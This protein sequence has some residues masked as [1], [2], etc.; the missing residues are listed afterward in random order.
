[1]GLK[2]TGLDLCTAWR[3]GDFSRS[4]FFFYKFTFK[5][6]KNIF[7]YHLK[8]FINKN[9]FLKQFE[10]LLLTFSIFLS[11]FDFDFFQKHPGEEEEAPT[12]LAPTLCQR[13]RAWRFMDW[14]HLA[15]DRD[16]W[17]A[18]VNTVINLWVW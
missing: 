2:E 8:I 10:L 11:F 7:T 6:F 1:L 9:T 18:V 13:P 12:W 17:W 15:L 4:F 16:Q 3:G 14:I 5:N